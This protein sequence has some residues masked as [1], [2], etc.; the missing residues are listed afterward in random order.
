MSGQVLSCRPDFIYSTSS[1]NPGRRRK[2][3]WKE[4]K[5]NTKICYQDT[6]KV[7]NENKTTAKPI[8]TYANSVSSPFTV[9]RRT[10]ANATLTPKIWGRI[11]FKQNNTRSC[12]RDYYQGSTAKYHLVYRWLGGR[13]PFALRGPINHFAT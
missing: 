8:M 7:E 3:K 2:Q 4:T 9:C 1:R 10:A 11:V 12:C 13:R 6:A 5:S